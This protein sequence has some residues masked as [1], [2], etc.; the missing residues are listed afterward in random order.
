MLGRDTTVDGGPKDAKLWESS[1]DSPPPPLVP[2]LDGNN[3]RPG[4]EGDGSTSGADGRGSC[5][6]Q[7]ATLVRRLR[8][9]ETVQGRG[10]R[11]RAE[12]RRDTH[13]V[14][15]YGVKLSGWSKRR[16]GGGEG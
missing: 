8:I 3:S 6:Q 11:K 1:S 14:M 16:R 9:H 7:T 12:R 13:H 2:G 5:G 15:W 4:F 10:P